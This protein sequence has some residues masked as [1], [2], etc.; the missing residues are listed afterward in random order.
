MAEAHGLRVARAI[1]AEISGTAP[2]PPFDGRGYCPIELGAESA[3]LVDGDWYA[4]PE[5]VVT[6]EGPSAERAGEKAEF[7]REH[8]ARW[9]GE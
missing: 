3:A 6:I 2:P 5:A 8:L 4:T 7:E 1:A 9:F